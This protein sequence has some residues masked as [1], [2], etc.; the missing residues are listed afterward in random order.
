MLQQFEAVQEQIIK[1]IIHQAIRIKIIMGSKCSLA[2]LL[3]SFFFLSFFISH[4][5][6]AVTKTDRMAVNSVKWWYIL[7]AAVKLVYPTSYH[8]DNLFCAK[9]GALLAGNILEVA[10][11]GDVF[12]SA[13]GQ[14][15]T[16][17]PVG[18][19]YPTVFIHCTWIVSF[20]ASYF[21]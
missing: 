18:K 8:L 7:A 14:R 13:K 20:R 4:F 19:P 6:V 12:L 11:F 16:F 15:G 10:G 5:R 21:R 17:L 3:A 2:Y 1:L 9:N